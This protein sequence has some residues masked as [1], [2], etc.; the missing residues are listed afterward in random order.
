MAGFDTSICFVFF[1]GLTLEHLDA[2]W[3]SVMK[4]EMLHVHSIYFL[5]NNTEYPEE[6]IRAV[7]NRYPWPVPVVFKSVK[8]GDPTKTQSWSV[9][10]VCQMAAPGQW[11]FFTRADYILNFDAVRRMRA[12]ILDR[13]TW[14][15]RRFVS[16]WCWQMAYDREARNTPEVL[17]IEQYH[18]RERG[19]TALLDHPYGFKFHE[20]D[21]DAGVWFTKQDFLAEA[22][23]MNEGLV[24]W[25]YQQSTF[26][27]A[28]TRIGITCSAVED[29]LF[30]HQHHYAERDFDKARAEYNAHGGGM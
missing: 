25:G 26:Q 13:P 5:D 12:E 22:G 1:R 20:T 17:D 29:Y 19:M 15:H 18:W 11:I 8:H 16:G 4:Q 9:N 23:W 6:A 2:A 3:F 10:H 27:R 21:Q 24:S 7:I 28:L 14:D 30:A